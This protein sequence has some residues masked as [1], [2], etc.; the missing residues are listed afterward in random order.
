MIDHV[1]RR[2]ARSDTFRRL[3]IRIESKSSSNLSV[4][5]RLLASSPR[6]LGNL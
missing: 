5:D 6:N 2:S 1:N 3:L 4:R